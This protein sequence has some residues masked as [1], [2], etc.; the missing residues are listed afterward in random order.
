MDD[1]LHPELNRG[2]SEEER[3]ELE[4]L[5]KSLREDKLATGPDV[6]LDDIRRYV[7]TMVEKMVR[8]S[9]MMLKF[10]DRIKSLYEIVR[11]SHKKSEAIND[12]I[13]TITEYLTGKKNA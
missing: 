1:E 8:L 11:L 12:R 9:D 6:S 7:E 10:D 4:G 13:T 5:I 2:L 3:D